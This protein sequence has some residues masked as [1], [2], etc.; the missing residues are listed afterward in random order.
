[1]LA[2]RRPLL[3]VAALAALSAPAAAA[4]PPPPAPVPVLPPADAGPPQPTLGPPA[5][6]P[7]V[8]PP[9]PPPP[10][11]DRPD[12]GPNG[13]VACPSPD[14]G[15]LFGV[16]LDFVKP[17][18]KD[19]VSGTAVFPDG[20]TAAVQLPAA[21]LAWTVAPSF[22]LG[23]RFPDDFG[24]LA[25]TYRFLTTAGDGRAPTPFGD[26]DIHSRLDLNQFDFDYVT[27][28]YS[29]TP[30]WDLQGRVGI[31][32][33]DVFFDTNASLLDLNLQGASN[34]FIG[35]GPHFS[36]AA[37]RRFPVVDGL[38][39]FGRID[40]GALVGQVHQRFR[41]QFPLPDGT[42]FAGGDTQQGTQTVPVLSLQAGLSYTPPRMD[43]IHFLFGYQFEDWWN[44]GRL[45]GSQG[46][47]S[48]QGLFVRGEFDF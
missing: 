5:A 6:G 3:A 15:L 47:F 48:D 25:F 20:S 41:E 17:H 1:M 28:P 35:A 39:A 42:T 36:L 32:L 46:S 26:L 33:A 40:G 38:A 31:R 11:F 19:R 2:R 16:E 27:A 37:E 30:F 29:P 9:P 34:N 13:W 14:E 7:V 43:Y 8:A 45:D 44:V 21:N 10:L 12:P 24:A 23:Y 18:L 4:Q 22:E